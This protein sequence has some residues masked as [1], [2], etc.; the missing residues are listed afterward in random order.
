[1]LCDRRFAETLRPDVRF[2]KLSIS[3]TADAHKRASRFRGRLQNCSDRACLFGLS[4]RGDEPSDIVIAEQCAHPDS[5]GRPREDSKVGKCARGIEFG[6][7]SR[8]ATAARL[9][10][11]RVR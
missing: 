7:K 4:R 2:A 6:W 5:E 8:G 3:R 1:M 11:P 10:P 9:K